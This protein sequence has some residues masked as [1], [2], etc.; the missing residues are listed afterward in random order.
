M[1]GRGGGG[2]DLED[3]GVDSRIRLKLILKKP[4]EMLCAGLAQ[5]SKFC[6]NGNMALDETKC[7][8]FFDK[9]TVW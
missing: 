1:W 7:Q 4:V 5:I 9:L 3:I 6:Q 2:K 8:N